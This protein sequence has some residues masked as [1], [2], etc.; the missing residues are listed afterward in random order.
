ML[1]LFVF[2]SVVEFNS[3]L[4][5]DA[6]IV[7]AACLLLLHCWFSIRKGVRFVVM[8]ICCG[9]SLKTFCWRPFGVNWVN[10][11]FHP[12]GVG[13]ASTGLWLGLWRDLFTCVGWQVTLCDSIWQVTSR[14]SEMTCSG[15]L[16]RLT[17]ILDVRC[18]RLSTVGDCVSCCSRS[19]V[20]QSSIARH[21]CPLSLHLLLSS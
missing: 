19:S 20:E 18:T 12:S 13:E 4:F 2:P 1:P 8:I 7:L 9:A 15:E 14:S 3:L 10:S 17:S 6:A 11:A 5:F 16:Y 21:C